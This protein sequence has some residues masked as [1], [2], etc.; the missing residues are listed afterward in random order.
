MACPAMNKHVVF[1]LSLLWWRPSSHWW[2]DREWRHSGNLLWQSLGTCGAEWMEHIGCNSDM[3]T[4]GI[5]IRRCKFCLVD[6]LMFCFTWVSSPIITLFPLSNCRSTS[7]TE[8]VL[9]K[10]QQDTASIYCCMY[11]TRGQTY[12][13]LPQCTSH[14]SGQKHCQ[15]CGCGRSL[16]PPEST[17]HATMWHSSWISFWNWQQLC[18]WRGE[19]YRQWTDWVQREA[20]DVLRRSVDSILWYWWKCSIGCLQAVGIHT[21]ILW[22]HQDERIK[23]RDSAIVHHCMLSQLYRGNSDY[24]GGVWAELELQ[25]CQ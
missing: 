15:I 24:N 8:L 2:S 5:S 14:W 6:E 23:S 20:G 13:V 16:L 4:T 7:S 17:H 25:S 19:A 3:S 22:A 18:S 9:W 10:T 12:R 1:C 11:W 21:I